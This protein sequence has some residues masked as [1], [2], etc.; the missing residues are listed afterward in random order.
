MQQDLAL[1]RPTRPRSWCSW[2]R[3]NRSAFSTIMMTALGTSTPTSMT[4]VEMSS[5]ISPAAKAAMAASFSLPFIL[6]WSSPRRYPA[7]GPRANSS[8]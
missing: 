1:P 8:M 7:K 5:C 6:P 4:V 2:L 3:P